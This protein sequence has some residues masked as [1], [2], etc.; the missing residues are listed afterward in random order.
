[1]SRKKIGRSSSSTKIMDKAIKR[2]NSLTQKELQSKQ[3]V[4]NKIEENEEKEEVD[5]QK[6]IKG[7]SIIQ[8]DYKISLRMDTIDMREIPHEIGI[9]IENN[10]IPKT[11]FHYHFKEDLLYRRKSKG[12]RK[13][14]TVTKSK[15]VF[16]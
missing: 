4:L 14:K 3:C 12:P 5:S 9:G 16:I 13:L 8:I 15:N 1:M 7:E 6:T 10:R 11:S 2:S